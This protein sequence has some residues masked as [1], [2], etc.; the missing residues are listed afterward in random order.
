[1]ND[2]NGKCTFQIRLWNSDI[3]FGLFLF[4]STEVDKNK[5]AN[6]INIFEGKK[7]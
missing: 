6:T 2:R 3:I 5:M 7:K 1:M 4:K